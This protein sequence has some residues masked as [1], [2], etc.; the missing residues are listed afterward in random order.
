MGK[1]AKNDRNIQ[2]WEWDRA[3]NI[4]LKISYDF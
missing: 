3:H 4:D 2:I 1:T